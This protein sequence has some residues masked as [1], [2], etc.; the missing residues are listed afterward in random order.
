MKKSLLALATALVIPLGAQTAPPLVS[1]GTAEQREDR[2]ELR[3]GQG[4]VRQDRRDIREDRR[5]FRGER[6]QYRSEYG[7][8]P[9]RPR[10]D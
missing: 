7:Q 2:R 8:R 3:E 1:S 6:R 9:A 5:D 10:V 4:E